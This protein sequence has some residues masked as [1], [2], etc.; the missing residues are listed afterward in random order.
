[1][2]KSPGLLGPK[3]IIPLHKN[4]L[5]SLKQKELN[6]KVFEFNLLLKGQAT[7]GLPLRAKENSALFHISS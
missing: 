5:L 6:R 7:R 1:M 2:V 4:F 3:R